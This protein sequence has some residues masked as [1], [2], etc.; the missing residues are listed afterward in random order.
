MLFTDIYIVYLFYNSFVG[1]DNCINFHILSLLIHSLNL[2]QKFKCLQFPHE[3]IHCFFSWRY[4]FLKP[5]SFYSYLNWLIFCL[6]AWVFYWLI[7]LFSNFLGTPFIPVL[8]WNTISYLSF[9]LG[10]NPTGL[11]WKKQMNH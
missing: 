11:C 3:L 8:G 7:F 6:D 1:V 10:E 9:S 4:Y 5:P 2:C